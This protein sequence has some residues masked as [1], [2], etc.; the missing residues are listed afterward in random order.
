M[1]LDIVTANIVPSLSDQ[2]FLFHLMGDRFISARPVASGS[3]IGFAPSGHGISRVSADFQFLPKGAQGAGCFP[4]T[5]VYGATGRARIAQ[6][7]IS[8]M[9]A[10]GAPQ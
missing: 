6:S 5:P 2:I 4:S 8:S 9:P 1:A 7:S 10:V 3:T